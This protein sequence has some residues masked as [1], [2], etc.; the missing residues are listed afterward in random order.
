[1]PGRWDFEVDAL[2]SLEDLFDETGISLPEGPYETVGGY[3][4][5]A[6]GRLPEIHDVLRHENVR[7][8]VLSVEGKRA[9]QLHIS[10]DEWKDKTHE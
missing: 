1:M 3:V 4:M 7:I 9:G 5:H 10:R 2:I 6:L 8:T